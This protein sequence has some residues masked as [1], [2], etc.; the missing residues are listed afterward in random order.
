AELSLALNNISSALRGRGDRIGNNLVLVDEYLRRLNPQLPAIQ[1]NFRGLADLATNYDKAVPDLLRLID[2]FSAVSRTLVDQKTQLSSFLASTTTF[3]GTAEDFL[4]VNENSLVRLASSSRPVSETYARYSPEFPCV[5]SGLT[6]QQIDAERTFG[7]ELPGLH[8]TLEATQD[9]GAFVPGDEPRWG[10]DRGPS[11]FGL[12]GRPI[13]PFP[14]YYEPK[15]G[16][17]DAAQARSPGVESGDCH[18]GSGP[19][20]AFDPAVALGGTVQKYVV[21][22]AVAPVL[23]LQPEAVPDVATLLFGPVA[24]GQLVSYQLG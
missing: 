20:A 18:A 22:R 5:L 4:R 17:C 7:G 16:Y 9:Q 23:R 3:A 24:R 14:A 15:D 19:S 13:V 21:A 12:T 10:E 11:C 6:R 2:N 8:I 1:Q